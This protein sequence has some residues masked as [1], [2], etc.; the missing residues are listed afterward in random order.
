MDLSGFFG[1]LVI[2]MVIYVCIGFFMFPNNSL[3]G[4]KVF[5][6]TAVVINA[7][8]FGGVLLKGNELE[9]SDLVGI[10]GLITSNVLGYMMFNWAVTSDKKAAE[11]RRAEDD[12]RKELEK[13][14]NILFDKYYEEAG[15]IIENKIRIIASA[16][17]KSVTSNS[18]GKKDYTKFIPELIEFIDEQPSMI[19]IKRRIEGIQRRIKRNHDFMI[20]LSVND[21]VIKALEGAI[22]ALDQDLG[23]TNDMGPFEYE[24]YCTAQ[25][26]KNGWDAEATQGSSDQGVDIVASKKGFIIVAQ[27][28]K[29]AKPVG[30][31]AVQEIVAGK[32]HYGANK[33]IVIAPNGFTNSAVKL[34]ESNNIDLI[35]HTE[36]KD[37]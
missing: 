1:F 7:S 19:D 12:L 37:L 20:T 33:G 10:L 8:V 3:L 21:K 24:H 36:I 34:A 18:F 4:Q 35:H 26:K 16:Y 5:Y 32:K 6:V 30:N 27:C 22:E 17:R 31:K 28:K 14:E 11:E 15:L 2:P 9:G 29:Y 13:E 23:Y 25:F